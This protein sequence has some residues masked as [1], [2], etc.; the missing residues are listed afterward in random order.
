MWP[1][2]V[3]VRCGEVGGLGWVMAGFWFPRG[4]DGDGFG[5]GEGWRE[6]VRTDVVGDVGQGGVGGEVVDVETIVDSWGGFGRGGWWRGDL[7]WWC[8]TL[9]AIPDALLGA[10]A[11]SRFAFGSQDVL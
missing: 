5:G 3:G 1:W 4:L 6:G 11:C 2:A 8:F 10:L 9:D 7:G